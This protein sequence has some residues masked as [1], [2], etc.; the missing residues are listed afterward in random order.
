MFAFCSWQGSAGSKRFSWFPTWVPWITIARNCRF[1]GV[2][3][4]HSEPGNHGLPLDATAALQRLELIVPNLGTIGYHCKE[5]PVPKAWNSRLPT[6]EPQVT[7]AKNFQILKIGTHGSQRG[8][9]RL[10]W[11]GIAGSQ[12]S[13]LTLPNFGTIGYYCKHLPLPRS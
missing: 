7:V 5:L 1:P 10:R 9:Q 13:K 8:N 11:Q 6:W 12:T 4:L 3:T 2:E